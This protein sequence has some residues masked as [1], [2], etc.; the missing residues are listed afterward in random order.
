MPSKRTSAWRELKDPSHS[1][2]NQRLRRIIFDHYGAWC[3]CCGEA[4]EVFLTI[5]HVYENGS[6]D[7]ALGRTGA[8][9]Y[10]HIINSKFPTSYQI[11][12]WN[13]N[14]AKRLVRVCPHQLVKA[15]EHATKDDVDV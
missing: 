14:E 7:R 15:A 12:C 1:N 3:A 11:L 5:D 4:F 10:R 8:S 6:I 13:C 9:L 2:Y